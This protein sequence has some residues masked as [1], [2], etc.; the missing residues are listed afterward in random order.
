MSIKSE[1]EIIRRLEASRKALE[2]FEE[3]VPEDDPVLSVGDGWIE[4]LEWVLGLS[5]SDMKEF[6]DTL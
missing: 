6:L 5:D 1:E 3:A 4:A 2:L